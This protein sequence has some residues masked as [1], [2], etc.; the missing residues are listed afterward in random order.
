[1]TYHLNSDFIPHPPQYYFAL[2]SYKFQM[3]LLP[4]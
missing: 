1:M 2:G 3:A 4:F